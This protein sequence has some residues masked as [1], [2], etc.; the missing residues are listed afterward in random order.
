MY[1]IAAKKDTS[2]ADVEGMH[3]NSLLR[4]NVLYVFAKLYVNLQILFIETI[5]KMSVSLVELC[6]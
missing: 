5:R 6:L 4:V 3:I 2:L 1:L